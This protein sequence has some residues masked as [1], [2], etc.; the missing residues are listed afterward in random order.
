LPIDLRVVAHSPV[1]VQT[2]SELRS[3]L[4]EYFLKDYIGNAMELHINT[5]G[6]L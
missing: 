6:D 4:V 1:S 5:L 3:G 2:R